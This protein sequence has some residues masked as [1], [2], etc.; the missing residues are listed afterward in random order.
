MLVLHRMPRIRRPYTV[1]TSSCRHYYP[2]TEVTWWLQAARTKRS[3]TEGAALEC[4]LPARYLRGF[5]VSSLL[6]FY[7]ASVPPSTLFRPPHNIN[8][9]CRHQPELQHVY[10]TSSHFGN[11]G[12]YVSVSPESSNHRP[13]SRPTL[14]TLLFGRSSLACSRF[15][16]CHNVVYLSLLLRP[17]GLLPR[18]I[19]R[20]ILVEGVCA[21]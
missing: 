6:D 7:S 11:F 1:C 4:F 17:I 12:S 10:W 21:L 16:A 20:T 13:Y 19:M 18:S 5:M 14:D 2:L 8:T 15:A 9:H 3:T